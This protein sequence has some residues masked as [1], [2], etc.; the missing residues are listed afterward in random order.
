MISFQDLDLFIFRKR[1]Q[2]NR[3]NSS[4]KLPIIESSASA[5]VVGLKIPPQ[6][7]FCNSSK[8]EPVPEDPSIYFRNQIHK[9]L[10]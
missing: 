9:V 10:Y 8:D 6:Y 5:L 1:C 2:Q 4:Y 7:R 3:D